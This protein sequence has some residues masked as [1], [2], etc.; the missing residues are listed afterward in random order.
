MDVDLGTKQFRPNQRASRRVMSVDSEQGS[1]KARTR[2]QCHP[3]SPN[4]TIAVG[5]SPLSHEVAVEGGSSTSMTA[6]AAE[7]GFEDDVS[8][9]REDWSWQEYLILLGAPVSS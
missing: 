9:L 7:D 5:S 8:C 6:D 2:S 1:I 4:V 3:A